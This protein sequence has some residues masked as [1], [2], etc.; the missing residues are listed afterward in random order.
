MPKHCKDKTVNNLIIKHIQ[1]ADKSNIKYRNTFDTVNLPVLTLATDAL[2]EAMDQC[3]YLQRM[4]EILK[5][6]T[7][8]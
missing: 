4:I 8:E 1:R 6:E 3:V 5:E 2:E 7:N